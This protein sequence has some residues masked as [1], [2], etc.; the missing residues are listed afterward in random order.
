MK[1]FKYLFFAIILSALFIQCSDDDDASSAPPLRDE[2]EVRLENEIEINDFLEQ[3]YFS[4]EENT[5][6]PNFER[7]VFRKL[8]AENTPE[9]AIPLIDSE[10]LES[11]TILQGEEEY[12]LFYLKIREGFSSQRKPTFAD[13]IL[14]TYEGFTIENQVF[15]GSSSPIW[16]DQTTVVT[17]FREAMVEYRGSSGFVENSDGSF[18]FNDDFGI[19]AVIIPSGLGYFA[20]PPANTGIGAYKPIVF[21]FQMYRSRLTDHDQD[22]IPSYMEDLNGTRRLNDVDT[23]GDRIFNYLDDDDDGDGVP[24]RE[25]IIIEEDGTIVFPDSNGNGTPDYLDPTYP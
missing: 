22:G 2:D 10:F 19:G 17:G 9:D 1:K 23:D 13:S 4:L 20:T 16:L 18:A 12:E 15:D 25:E 5:N 8:D 3:Y 7:I 6:N 24:T 14:I 21:T 11:K